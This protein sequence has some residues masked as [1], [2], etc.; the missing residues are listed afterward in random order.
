MLLSLRRVNP[1]QT[2][3]ESQN[4]SRLFIQQ[5]CLKQCIN[6][7][8]WV[9]IICPSSSNYLVCKTKHACFSAFLEGA[10]W[11]LCYLLDTQEGS[12]VLLMISISCNQSG[13]LYTWP[14]RDL[15]Y[16]SDF[17]KSEAVVLT[18]LLIFLQL[19]CI[20]RKLVYRWHLPR[21]VGNIYCFIERFHA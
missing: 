9:S 5:K 11:R 10:I 19:F 8:T 4:K 6:E 18:I 21:V 2:F 12:R 17:L 3:V 7:D 16:I 1:N 13:H 15:L 20:L 14:I